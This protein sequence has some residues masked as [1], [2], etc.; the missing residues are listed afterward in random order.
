MEPPISTEPIVS[1]RV[2]VPENFVGNAT[3]NKTCM[4][5]GLHQC[6]ASLVPLSPDS[7]DSPFGQFNAAE[8]QA[9]CSRLSGE[10]QNCEQGR[11]LDSDHL[12]ASIGSRSCETIQLTTAPNSTTSVE[13]FPGTT[14]PAEEAQESTPE[15]IP[16][17]AIPAES[18]SNTETSDGSEIGWTAL[19][20]AAARGGDSVL[21]ML[22]T[23]GSDPNRR[24]RLGRAALHLA[25]QNGHLK[26]VQILLCQERS[27]SEQ[28]KRQHVA[29]VN[30]Q[31]SGGQTP[32]HIAVTMSREDILDSLLSTSA[33]NLEIKDRHGRTALHLAVINGL[34][35][36][37]HFLLTKRANVHS[38]IGQ[39]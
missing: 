25:V 9:C 36:I 14:D 29:D 13:S 8:N 2:R 10:P 33:V 27:I 6:H 34:D 7:W 24:D 19:H 39:P 22:L 35:D 26:S 4:S 20:V 15:H 32:V 17:D 3:G 18:L 12:P 31:D 37:A 30:L 28:S 38:I 11:T 23:F 5:P 21:Q 1:D 16:G